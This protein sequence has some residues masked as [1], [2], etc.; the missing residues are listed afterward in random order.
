MIVN[1]GS[2]RACLD[3]GLPMNG[4]GQTGIAKSFAV[5][6]NYS[7]LNDELLP[8]TANLDC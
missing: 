5:I 7:V 8:L 3:T 2:T 1:P 4:T 6:F